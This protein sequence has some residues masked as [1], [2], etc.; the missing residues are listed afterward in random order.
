MPG[1][2]TS[3]VERAIAVLECFSRKEPALT[4]T[5]ISQ[6]LGLRKST[7]HRL[8]T[9][10]ARQDM[11]ARDVASLRYRLGPKVLYLGNVCAKQYRLRDFAM[12][13]M[14][15]VWEKC[16]ETV[17]LTI[18]VGDHR[19]YLEQIESLQE[20]RVSVEIGKL[21][22]ISC[23]ASGKILLAF[24]DSDE[25]EQILARLPLTPLTPG[26]ITDLPPLR[27]APPPA[28]RGAGRAAPPPAPRSSWRP[29]GRPPTPSAGPWRRRTPP[30]DRRCRARTET[31][32]GAAP[33]SRAIHHLDGIR[34]ERQ[35]APPG[36]H[37]HPMEP[38][39]ARP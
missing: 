38:G 30:S 20:M 22:P 10:L 1:S 39:R 19:M 32:P 28:P 12:P 21:L 4:I 29:R 26:T 8:L 13:I 7:V 35:V 15:Q 16:G 3:A 27:A 2:V 33:G 11:I 9:L 34:F 17:T 25:A 6:R 23:G 14:R 36:P 18:R 31:R 5:E 37:H 24:M